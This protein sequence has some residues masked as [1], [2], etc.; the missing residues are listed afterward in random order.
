[1]II[2]ARDI[3]ADGNVTPRRVL[4][5]Q[6]EPPVVRLRQVSEVTVAADRLVAA[7]GT[8]PEWVRDKLGLTEEYLRGLVGQLAVFAGGGALLGDYLPEVFGNRDVR[9]T[10]IGIAAGLDGLPDPHRPSVRAV[11]DDL[12]LMGLVP[13]RDVDGR[14]ET[15]D[16]MAPDRLVEVLDDIAWLV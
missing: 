8:L 14:R 13:S 2:A 3:D 5:G 4:A 15:I 10:L 16:I 1:Q 11:V 7:S 9:K 6:D 12:L